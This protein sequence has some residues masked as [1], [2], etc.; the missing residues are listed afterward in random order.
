[1]LYENKKIVNYYANHDSIFVERA[2]DSEVVNS[3]FFY[4]SFQ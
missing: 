2:Q 4:L 3:R 1:M